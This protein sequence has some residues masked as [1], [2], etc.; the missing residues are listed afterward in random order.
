[1]HSKSK[2]RL[3][4]CPWNSP[5]GSYRSALLVTLCTC[6]LQLTLAHAQTSV[7]T[8]HYDNARS[9]VNLNETLLTPSNVV[10]TGFGKLFTQPVDGY[11]VGHPLYLPGVNI[12]GKGVHNVLFVATMHNSVYAFDADDA[13][14]ANAAPLWVTS[15][16]NYS[17][18]GATPAPIS[19]V[20][21]SGE[22][23]WTEVGVISTPV[24]D[25]QTSTIYL[26]AETYE[27][28]TLVH[29]LHALDL[30][31]GVE[32]MGGPT[33]IAAT[34][35]LNGAT[36]TFVSSKQINRP[37]LLLANGHVYAGFGSN[38]CNNNNQ[39]WILSYNAGTLQQEGVF[40]SEPGGF[41]ASFWQ[42]GA[43]LSADPAGNIYGETGEGNVNAGASFGMSV[44]KLS[45]VGTSLA[46]T[47]WFTP[48]NWLYLNQH[49]LD[50]NDG[51][52]ILPDQPGSHPH[53]LIG[54]GKQ[55]TVYLLDRDNMG[56]LCTSC[57]S[58]D[59]Q[60]VQELPV[61]VG[62]Q[63]GTPIFWNNKIYF[64]PQS[65]PVQ[66]Y[67]VRNGVLV[68]PP[69]VQ[70]VKVGGGGHAIITSNGNN[71][72]ILWMINGSGPLWAMDANT[73]KVLY[74]SSQA[75]NGR[76]TL[77]GLAHFA[78][79]VSADGKV[80]VGTRSSLVVYGLLPGLLPNG[81]NYQTG[82]VATALLTPLQVR[83]SDPYSG[84]VFPG[85]SVTFSDGGKGGTFSSTTA[86]TDSTGSASTTYNLPSKA[87][88]YTLTAN[89]TGFG[90][91]SFSET[92]T[93]GAA[94][95]LAR[96]S[97]NLQT[98]SVTTTLANPVVA[99][100]KDRYGNA[101]P[102]VAVA[103]SDGGAGGSFSANPVTTS[104][105]GQAS[106]L[107]TA[108][109]KSGTVTISATATG[110]PVLKFTETILAGPA[111]SIAVTSGNNQAAAPSTP[112]VQPLVVSVKD[113][114]GN[115][116]S[117][118]AVTFSDSAMG[119][120]FSANPVVTVANGTASVTYTTPPSSG[121]VF[122]TAGVSGIGSVVTFT[123]TVQ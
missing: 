42:K 121:T 4:S 109:T 11:I 33:T 75:P 13:K 56:Q 89:A 32:K 86:V 94:T 54:I 24:I 15:L 69:T 36:S 107:Y 10:S 112:L 123:V 93:P 16:L 37:G 48:Y 35:S 102:G 118:V 79:P 46:L 96:S 82:T 60:I 59:T 38:G 90:K 83:L 120:N 9:S 100:A 20:G 80:F 14:G 115:P 85:V 98:A 117:G 17:P 7:V 27:N 63:T 30:S 104:S 110:I 87:A 44:I 122:V 92:A 25:P 88:T 21:C 58:G 84:T 3:F 12:A 91:G 61:Q 22:T 108:S 39:G 81:G 66:A 106:A 105:K 53:E 116:V 65:N 19:V 57:T 113:Q 45:Q 78:S 2:M 111:T 26:V 47:D 95:A 68:T 55:G 71:N 103:F 119:G 5:R 99:V 28:S 49:D 29:R 1:V 34:F 41:Y 18:A 114:Y 74:T 62:P 40:D 73:L 8:W 64:T 67:T 77:P 101:V 43:G 72:G 51:I 97:G 70:S 31:S 6:M 50:L 76:D 52:L 23:A